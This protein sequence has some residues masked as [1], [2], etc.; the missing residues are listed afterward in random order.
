MRPTVLVLLLCATAHAQIDEPSGA[1]RAAS[2]EAVP[3]R[4]LDEIDDEP[5]PRA[6]N[7][8]PSLGASNIPDASF[9]AV[10]G[11][12]VVVRMRNGAELTGHVLAFEAA[13]VSLAMEP[14]QSVVTLPRAEVAELR[15]VPVVPPPIVAAPSPT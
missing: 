4:M 6:P 10:A 11:R 15:L 12:A 5:S 1:R 13:T 2:G 8:Q 7:I 3:S 14:S 9:R